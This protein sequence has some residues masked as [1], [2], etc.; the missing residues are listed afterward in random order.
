MQ[1]ELTRGKVFSTLLKFAIPL[2]ISGLLQQLYSIVDSLIVGNMIGENA[3]AA[4]GASGPIVNVFIYVLTG[5][6]SGC[7][8]L[9]SHAYG[10]GERQNINKIASSFM[11]FVVGAA[12]VVTIVGLAIHAPLLS[13]LR[14]PKELISSASQYLVIMFLGVPFLAFYNLAGAILRGI[15][16]S[17]TP[18]VAIVIASVINIGLDILFVGPMN[19]GIRGAAIAT[20]I[21]QMFSAAYLLYYLKRGNHGFYFTL[22][23]KDSDKKVLKEGLKL[24]LPRVIQSSVSSMGSFLLQNVMNSFGV[25]T[26]AAITTAYKID[27]LAI[28]PLLNV[29]VAISVFTGQNMGSGNRERATECLKKGLILMCGIAAIITAIFVTSG[30]SL[31]KLFGVSDEAAAIGQRFFYIAAAFYPILGISE[32]ISGFLQGCKDVNFTAIAN[33]IILFVRV[34]ISY[35]LLGLIAGDVIAVAEVCA[36]TLAATVFTWR[37]K[38][39]KW[40]KHMFAQDR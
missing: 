3:L 9:V 5:L 1:N 25:T 19:M 27:S 38:S 7:T 17:K 33:I 36:W 16:N 30:F 28:L 14:T 18:L 23:R 32:G 22:S 20:V 6:V 40:K 4:A 31:I 35:A 34:G 10:A 24:S 26:V 11:F 13:L 15:G 29:S 39:G 12:I 2:I 37:Y 21:A 8:I